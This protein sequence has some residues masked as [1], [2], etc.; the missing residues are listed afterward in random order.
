MEDPGSPDGVEALV[1]RIDQA[2]FTVA[3]RGF[4]PREVQD[5]LRTVIDDIRG[6]NLGDGSGGSGAVSTAPAP[7]HAPKTW[8]KAEAEAN[9]LV[10]VAEEKAQAIID[11]AKAEAEAIR[12]EAATTLEQART[13]LLDSIRNANALIGRARTET[14]PGA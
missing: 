11:E 2:R 10:R 9:E 12:A 13:A 6:L 8:A 1:E 5:F 3:F 4:E 14:E 7:P